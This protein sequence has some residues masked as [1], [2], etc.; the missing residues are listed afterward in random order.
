MIKKFGDCIPA[1]IRQGVK[2]LE[3]FLIRSPHGIKGEESPVPAISRYLF[4]SQ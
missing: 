1:R 2:F 4:T 3:L